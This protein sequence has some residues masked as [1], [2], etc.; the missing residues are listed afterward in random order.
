MS[1]PHGGNPGGVERASSNADDLAETSYRA[2][3]AVE[4]ASAEQHHRGAAESGDLDA[5]D[6]LGAILART[7][8]LPEAEQWW[9]RAAEAGHFV[10][11]RKLGDLLYRTGR[12][13][14][15]EAW[16]AR[17]TPTDLG[18]I[19]RGFDAAPEHQRSDH[20]RQPAGP[21]VGAS[22]V[23]DSVSADGSGDAGP[24][25]PHDIGI[26]VAGVDPMAETDRAGVDP[27]AE[28]DRAGADPMAETDRAGA[29]PMAET[30]QAGDADDIGPWPRGAAEAGDRDAMFVLGGDLYEQGDV[31]EAVRW[32]RRAAEA[33]Q[34]TAMFFLS[35]Y[36]SDEGQDTEAARWLQQAADQGEPA[37]MTAV[38]ARS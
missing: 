25:E 4:N 5:M 33:D 28:T 31:A 6:R 11:A 26:P 35:L 13:D 23:D 18:A 7:D 14:E 38:G 29:D 21:A 15:A 37:A 30:G 17:S 32:W 3:S 16:W 9:R 20:P 34:P 36:L 10:A 27:M 22:R 24:D 12:P 2:A 8:R 19:L 1:G